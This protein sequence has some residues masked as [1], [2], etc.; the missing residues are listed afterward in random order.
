MRRLVLASTSPRRQALLREAGIAFDAV[1]PWVDEKVAQGT[2]PVEAAVELAVRK[3]MAVDAGRSWV[4]AADTLV[5]LDGDILGKPRDR[6][7]ARETLARLSGREHWIVTGVAL[8]S[9]TQGMLTG[10]AQTRVRFRA[11]APREVE[12]YVATG[13]PM[14]KAGAY[15][16]QG[17]AA[18]FVDELRGP[19]DNVVGLP[20][21]VVRRLLT[22]SGFFD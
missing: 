15:A 3:A 17:G 10:L 6:Q 14:D 5:D 21:D 16:I 13:E 7:H 19:Q 22:E 18:R 9:P 12:D 1:A 11:L 2:P 20:M 8:R 4:L